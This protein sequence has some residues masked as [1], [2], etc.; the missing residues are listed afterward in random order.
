M[1]PSNPESRRNIR[2]IPKLSQ[3]LPSRTSKTSQK[4]V[5][6]PDEQRHGGS[7]PPNSGSEDRTTEPPDNNLDL[8]AQISRSRAELMPKEK[9]AREFSRMTAYF[10]CEEFDL[11]AVA[12]FLRKI[13]RSSQDYTMRR[14]MFHI[15]Y[16][17][18]RELTACV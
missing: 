10:I 4:L 13:T 15:H 11:P 17:C 5:L 14:C 2:S 8:Q 16:H 7:P 3:S 1:S 12:K 6:I 9:R 18:Y